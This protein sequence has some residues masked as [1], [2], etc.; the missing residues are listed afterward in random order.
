MVGNLNPNDEVEEVDDDLR[1][2]REGTKDRVMTI[3]T[4]REKGLTWTRPFG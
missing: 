4:I 1:S 3:K 2:N